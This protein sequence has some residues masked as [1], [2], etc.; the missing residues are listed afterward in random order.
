MTLSL[1]K[2]ISLNNSTKD[3]DSGKIFERYY[4]SD[5]SLKSLLFYL[6]PVLPE[7]VLSSPA[8][9]APTSVSTSRAPVGSLSLI[10][11]IIALFLKV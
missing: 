3:R 8:V 11:A 6:C 4:R 10:L 9:F 7:W 1:T 2:N 5:E